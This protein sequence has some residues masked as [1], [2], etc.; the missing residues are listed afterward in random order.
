MSYFISNHSS[1]VHTKEHLKSLVSFHQVSTFMEIVLQDIKIIK[2]KKN[3]VAVIPV[4][5]A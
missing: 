2:K 4:C 1:Y 3:D 5:I